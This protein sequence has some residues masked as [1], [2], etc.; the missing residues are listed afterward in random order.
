M[1]SKHIN[2]YLTPSVIR[3]TQ[4]KVTVRH[5]YTPSRVAL[6]L[7]RPMSPNVEKDACGEIG[8]CIYCWWKRK[9][10]RLFQKQFQ[11]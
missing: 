2:V 9:V 7:K 11:F 6:V 4:V 3:E 1:T 10:A 8:T 5:K